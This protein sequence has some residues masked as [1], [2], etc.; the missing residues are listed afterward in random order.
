MYGGSALTSYLENVVIS[1]PSYAPLV[2]SINVPLFLRQNY[3]EVGVLSTYD[4]SMD[5]DPTLTENQGLTQETVSG[6]NISAE[7][8]LTT[9][10]SRKRVY[11]DDGSLADYI[12]INDE[13]HVPY[14]IGGDVNTANTFN[15]YYLGNGKYIGDFVTKMTY[16]DEEGNEILSVTGDTYPAQSAITGASYIEFEYVLGG[17]FT[18]KEII[19]YDECELWFLDLPDE[20]TIVLPATG[21]TVDFTVS[22]SCPWTAYTVEGGDEYLNLK[23]T[24]NTIPP[25]TTGDV[26]VGNIYILTITGVSGFGSREEVNI[27]SNTG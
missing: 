3:G 12:I 13:P 16:Y 24:Y 22:G 21:G 19:D 6:L 27:E 20:T 23:H 5:F 1:L 4:E 14:E 11:N 18:G 26:L 2:P 25:V 17:E 10:R 15:T 7:S 8:K 9:L